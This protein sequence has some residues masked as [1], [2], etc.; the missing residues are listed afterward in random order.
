MPY[1]RL[2]DAFAFASALHRGQ[3]RTGT[4]IPYI[5]HPMAVSSLVLTHGGDEDQAIAA[6][7]HDAVEDQGG[8]AVARR[9]AERFGPRVAQMV[10]AA[11]DAIVERGQ[12]KPAWRPR[13]AA[14]IARLPQTPP[15]AAL[16][17]TCDKLH[18]LTSLVADVAREGPS[19]LLRFRS[20]AGLV[21][22][23]REVAQALQPFAGSAPVAELRTLARRFA[24]QLSGHKLPR[25]GADG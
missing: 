12:P 20:P 13:K 19:T 7:L 6:L 1:D 22:Y 10:L 24:A 11:S 18:N 9:I 14:F 25:G 8:L 23:Y 3:V 4:A 2:A 5:S 17:I 16:V 21:W 15:A